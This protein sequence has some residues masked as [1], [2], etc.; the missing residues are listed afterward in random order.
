MQD[1]PFADDLKR[2]LA[3]RE[4]L[5]PLGGP[6]PQGPSDTSDGD[7]VRLSHFLE[8]DLNQ[9][10][11]LVLKRQWE[12]FRAERETGSD[13]QGHP[14]SSHLHREFHAGACGTAD[15]SELFRLFEE[16]AQLA[17]GSGHD[18]ES[19]QTLVHHCILLNLH[20]LSFHGPEAQAFAA[21]QQA[22]QALLSTATPGARETFWYSHRW[23]R[24]KEDEVGS[25]LLEV[26][27]QALANRRVE[28]GWIE[29]F[30]SAYLPLLE[31]EARFR[32]LQGAIGRKAENPHLT[33]QELE[34]LE[35]ADRKHTEQEMAR[36]RRTLARSRVALL[37]GPGGM[38]L[39]DLESLGYEEEC[40]R[41]LRE[42]YRLTHPD[43]VGHH[44]FTERQR[45]RLI[46][47]YREAV[48]CANTAGIDD[49]EI[50]LGMRSLA[51]L[52][53]ILARVRKIWE[54]KGLDVNEGAA[55]R[56]DTLAD[57]LEWLDARITELEEQA[58]QVRA[59]LLT[60]ATDPDVAEKRACLR[61][62]EQIAAI[63]GEMEQKRQWYEARTPALEDRLQ[64]LF[65]SGSE[66][67]RTPL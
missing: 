43:V 47:H 23:W 36:L 12:K 37:S 42:I 39:D 24:E 56:G 29:T 27:G 28:R 25:L 50:A 20:V 49:E 58:K 17:T 13:A 6:P 45:E 15:A 8:L 40:R 52:E 65:E 11:V 35:A 30:G 7:L 60:V 32:S 1:I 44:G 66:S 3:G 48:A 64:Q 31:A 63:T 18:D 33:L 14:G 19:F 67:D 55:I 10:V 54:V 22:Q 61:S 21:S 46:G 26:E 38:P 59:D 9:A 5:G 57:R 2:Y 62:Q 4:A 16:E 34:D 51:S 41:L 53:A